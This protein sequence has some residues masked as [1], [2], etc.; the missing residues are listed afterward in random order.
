MASDLDR[1]RAA[2][3]KVA[4]LVIADPIYAPIF[5][6]LEQELALVEAE[7]D[8]VARAHAEVARQSAMA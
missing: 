5:E 4:K 3:A 7:G 6:R 1:I 2:H 8:T